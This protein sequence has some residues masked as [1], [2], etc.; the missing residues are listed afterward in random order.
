MKAAIISPDLE[1]EFYTSERCHIVELSNSQDD[2]EVSIARVRVEPG[3]TTQWH[4]LK[5]P[6][7]RYYI[8]EGQ[9]RMEIGELSPQDITPGFVV[10]IPPMCRQRITNTGSS[11]LLFLAICSPRFSVEDYIECGD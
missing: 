6:F 8:L 4:Q 3:V 10:L 11:D 9:G 2:P 7:E 1:T 5:K